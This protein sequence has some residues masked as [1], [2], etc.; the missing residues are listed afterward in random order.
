MFLHKCHYAKE[1][2]RHQSDRFIWRYVQP[3]RQAL[4]EAIDTLA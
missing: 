1:A 4:A 3:D 2:S